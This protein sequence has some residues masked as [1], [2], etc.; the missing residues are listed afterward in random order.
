VSALVLVADDDPFQLRLLQEV[1][2]AAGHAVVTAADG[3]AVLDAIA[4]TRPDLVLLDALMPSLDGLEVLRILK[5]DPRLA[6]IPVILVTDEHD[7]ESRARGVELGADDYLARP[8]RV[9]EVQQ[10]VRNALR[11]R[12]AE[13]AAADATRRVREIDVIDPLTRAGTAPQLFITLH[14]EHV[15]A[16][17]YAHPLGVAVVRL[18]NLGE[19]AATGGVDAADGALVQLV[20]GLRLCTRDIDQVFRASE[21][22][23]ALVM[24]ETD[25][26][27]VA[28]VVDR[29]SAA[30]RDGTLFAARLVPAPIIRIGVACYPEVA[31]ASAQILL[32]RAVLAAR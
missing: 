30:E 5:A 26:T 6:V 9:F 17:R 1:C 31:A 4:R 28:V 3:M 27:G 20:A 2:E 8:L 13:S 11:M 12:H 29:L 21:D 23:L 18:A 32:E 22:E 19:L 24:P 7:E 14:Y 10:R 25:A 15:R 16:V